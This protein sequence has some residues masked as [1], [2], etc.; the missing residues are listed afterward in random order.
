M[1]NI[2]DLLKNFDF[3][4]SMN[5][6]AYS[7]H[8]DKELNKTFLVENSDTFEKYK[9]RIN[10]HS[11]PNSVKKELNVIKFLQT[12]TQTQ[13]ILI[14]K[15]IYLSNDESLLVTNFINGVSLDTLE[16]FSPEFS[17]EITAKTKALLSDLHHA[18]YNEIKSLAYDIRFDNWYEYI[19]SL[20]KND[21]D[22]LSGSNLISTADEDFIW[23]L[24]NEHREYLENVRPCF[25]HGDLKPHNIIWNVKDRTLHLIDFESC[26]IGD[27][28]FDN[29]RIFP[30]IDTSFNLE[31][32]D[33]VF[34]LYR[35]N[36]YL[37]WLANAYAIKNKV[38]PSAL[39]EVNQVLN[40]F[41]SRSRTII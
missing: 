37:H 25:V 22:R 16:P 30:D 7:I 36:T 4:K 39:S 21:F 10:T 9:V 31:K 1:K 5:F 23:N 14:P 8:S 2:N 33:S 15:V 18:T 6:R 35:L 19:K 26:R 17:I 13:K 34:W 28:N 12:Q 29:Y 38:E 20:F 41:K 40:R 3:F 11:F 32:Q 27:A 24:I